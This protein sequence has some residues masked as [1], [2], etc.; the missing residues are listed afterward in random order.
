[1]EIKVRAV[2]G[3]D[4]KSKAEIEEQLL[5]KHEEE[6]NPQE[7]EKTEVVEQAVITE[8]TTETEQNEVKPQNE[9]TPSSE[10]NDEDVLSYLKNRY[11]KDIDS[12]DDLFAEKEANDPLPE[13]VSAYLKYKQE[14]GRGIN[15]FY[16][17]QR[18][19]DAMEDDA[20][21]AD[22]IATQ[23]EGL[24]AIDIQDIMEDKFSF[25][26]ELD[27]P[28]DI[29]KKKLAKKR[30]LA[31]AKKFFNEQKDKY[32]IPLESS[33]GGLSEDQEKQLNAYRKALEESKTV[34]EANKKKYDYFHEKTKEVFSDEFK[35]FEFNVGEKDITFKPGSKEELY[36][37][38]KDF[39]N[40][41]KK[42]V[43]E[44]GLIKDANAYHKAMAV[45]L[46]PDRF[47]RH[48]YELGVSQTVENVSKKSKNINMDIR[49][50][51]RL[52]TK[53]G[54]KIRSVQSDN[55]SSGRGLKIRSIK[56]M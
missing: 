43:N 9:T 6:T 51:P 36:N 54:L 17:L 19:Y 48:F 30:E 46:N 5:K 27:D 38:Q 32:K 25:D 2:E 15:D 31:K 23:E 16:N 34:E 26:E 52:V 56:K 21:L 53:D 1:M 4:N 55:S 44:D 42:F 22:Y 20:V 50:A 7:V 49:K 33:G 3:S 39:T 10:L 28:K 40:F 29:K 8:E 12:V 47:A 35:G 45:A 24:D 13:D 14:T 11:N 37:V 18:D 41:R